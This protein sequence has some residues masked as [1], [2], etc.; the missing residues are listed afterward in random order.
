MIPKLLYEEAHGAMIFGIM[1]RPC[2]IFKFLKLGNPVCRPEVDVLVRIVLRGD[3]ADFVA[4]EAVCWG[5]VVSLGAPRAQ[6]DLIKQ[7]TLNH[8]RDLNYRIWG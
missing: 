3:T 8:I 4:L 6:Y 1:K 5:P 7:Y 2:S